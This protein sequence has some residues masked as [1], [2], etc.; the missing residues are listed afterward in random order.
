MIQDNFTPEFLR[1]KVAEHNRNYATRKIEDIKTKIF[2]A[3][4]AEDIGVWITFIWA[5]GDYGDI[6]TYFENQGFSVGSPTSPWEG[7]ETSFWFSWEE[8]DSDD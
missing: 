6:I 8:D 5:D 1:Q 4:V 7:D 3:A 2:K